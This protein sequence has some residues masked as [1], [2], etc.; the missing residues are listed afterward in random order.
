MP[1][2]TA[3]KVCWIG[4]CTVPFSAKAW[5]TRSAPAGSVMP[6]INAG[7]LAAF[8]IAGHDVVQRL[9]RAW[10]SLRCSLTALSPAYCY[11]DAKRTTAIGGNRT[12][13]ILQESPPSSE[14]HS[15][16]LVE[17]K[18]SRS[19]LESTASAWRHTKS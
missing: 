5:N 2:R 12:S 15:P 10:I 4:I 16:P 6:S 7:H 11:A 14:I 3:Q 9:S 1:N 19:P 8:D 17:P 18:A 13:G